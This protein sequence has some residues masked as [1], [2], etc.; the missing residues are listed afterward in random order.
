MQ[1]LDLAIEVAGGKVREIHFPKGGVVRVTVLDYDVAPTAE[2]VEFNQMAEPFRRTVYEAKQEPKP[3]GCN[4]HFFESVR[5]LLKRKFGKR[6][7]SVGQLQ[8]ML[9]A[10]S[11]LQ[12]TYGG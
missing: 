10:A 12:H 11:R 2:G 5:A 8:G 1:A 7:L 9:D 4:V 3:V 6:D